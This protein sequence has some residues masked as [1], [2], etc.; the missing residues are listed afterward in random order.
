MNLR[1]AIV[2]A[3]T[4]GLL[5]PAAAAAAPAPSVPHDPVFG[6]FVFGP[7][8]PGGTY[9]SACDVNHDGVMN[10]LDVQLTAGRWNQ[11]GTWVSDNNHNHLGQTWIGASNPLKIQGTFG[12]PDYAALVLNNTAAHGLAIN[13]V[14]LDGIYIGTTGA[15]GMVVNDAAWDGVYVNAAGNPSTAT[16]SSDNNG[17]EVAGAQGYGL[18]VG[19]A[20]IHGVRVAS[21]GGT[22]LRVD[23]AN[24]GVDVVF[25]NFTGA[26]AG[27]TQASGQWGFYTD[28]AIHGSNVTLSSLTVTA[29]VSGAQALNSGDVVAAVGVTDPFPNSTVP[30]ALV[31]LA[32]ATTATGIVG[33]VE[34][35]MAL[36]PKPQHEDEQDS[37]PVVELRSVDGPAQPGDYV[38]ITVLGAA[39]V[40]VQGNE[41]LQPGQRVTVGANGGVRAL[42]TIPM[43][44]ADG[45]QVD[46]VESAPVL[47]VTLDAVEDGMVWV[48][49]NPR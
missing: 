44:R 43:L 25:A 31:S 35:R 36:I 42:R 38:A 9:E 49:V 17:F 21:A 1:R 18:Y 14:G 45:G 22:G 48:L 16:F 3:L 37:E 6:D 7:C 34:G 28:D 20:D 30:L 8:A 41:T 10:V 4:V 2:L 47:G 32:N 24:Y 39:Q 46:M 26:Y 15:Y 13:N 11:T 40:K 23:S 29:Q 27:T 12:A 33:V 5:L 19:R